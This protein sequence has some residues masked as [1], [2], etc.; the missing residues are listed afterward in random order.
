MSE[1]KVV[2]KATGA[3]RGS[4][5]RGG[6]LVLGHEVKH[7]PRH[8]L[9]PVLEHVPGHMLEHVLRPVLEHVPGHMLEHVP[10]HMLEHVPGHMLEHVHKHV[11]G[12]MLG[13]NKNPVFQ[14]EKIWSEFFFFFL[15]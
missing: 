14:R 2:C 7:V 3:S 10:G 1:P 9:R 6:L 12:H 5:L 11:L 15:C 8:V 13:L 4:A